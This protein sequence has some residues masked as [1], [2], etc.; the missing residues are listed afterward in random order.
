MNI[1]SAEDKS[2]CRE[3][4]QAGPRTLS[5]RTR[6]LDS[7]PCAGGITLSLPLTQGE[8]LPRTLESKVT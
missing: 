8:Q 7:Q 1:S 5:T 2:M 6:G 3:D 4:V